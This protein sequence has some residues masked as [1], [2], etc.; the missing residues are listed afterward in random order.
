VLAAWALTADRGFLLKLSP[1]LVW[2]AYSA[3]IAHFAYVRPLRSYRCPQC[4]RLLPRVED[5][6]PWIRF[7]CD[8]CGVEW[9]VQRSHGSGGGD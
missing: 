3:I 6:R 2:L 5:A 1:M 4:R 9:D 8:A 7:R